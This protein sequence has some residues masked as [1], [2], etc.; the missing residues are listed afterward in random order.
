MEHGHKG[1]LHPLAA[2]YHIP[3]LVLTKKDGRQGKNFNKASL[4]GTV[5]TEEKNM[6]LPFGSFSSIFLVK[7]KA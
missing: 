6:K 7:Q 4:M 2:Y 3:H 5:F 1:N